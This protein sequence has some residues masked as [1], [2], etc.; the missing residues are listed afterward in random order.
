MPAFSTQLPSIVGLVIG[1]HSR[2]APKLIWFIIAKLI[3]QVCFTWPT[4]GTSLTTRVTTYGSGS[5]TGLP[6]TALLCVCEPREN[7]TEKRCASE[8]L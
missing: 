6:R 4:V 8:A 7:S 3:T 2:E 5:G 1:I